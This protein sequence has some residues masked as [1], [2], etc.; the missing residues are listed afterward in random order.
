MTNRSPPG[1]GKGPGLPR[2]PLTL[3]LNPSSV[4]R[5]KRRN[6]PSG[7]TRKRS[8]PPTQFPG[9]T[10]TS[11]RELACTFSI[12]SLPGGS[13]GS[14]ALGSVPLAQSSP[15]PPDEAPPAPPPGTHG[16]AG[17]GRRNAFPSFS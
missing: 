8:F 4:T 12:F 11:I 15:Q 1:P 17:E 5:K 7:L 9:G 10:H 16:Q 14:E 2:G 6:L 13:P 3:T